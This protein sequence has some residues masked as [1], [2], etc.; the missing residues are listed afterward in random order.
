MKEG[1]TKEST[2]VVRITTKTF[3]VQ[4]KFD[5][6]IIKFLPASDFERNKNNKMVD[7][8]V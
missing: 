4:F 2:N 7:V 5:L 8:T 3:Y 6:L 1:Y